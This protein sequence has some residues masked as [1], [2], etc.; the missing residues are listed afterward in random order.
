MTELK[1]SLGNF[2]KDLYQAEERI[3]KLENRSFEIFQLEKQKLK[4]IKKSK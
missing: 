3:S 1:N 2:N 4:R